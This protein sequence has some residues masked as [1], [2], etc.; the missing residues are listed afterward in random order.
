[1]K[2]TLLLLMTLSLL[3]MPL[4]MANAEERKDVVDTAVAAGQFSILVKA[5]EQAGLVE[6]LKGS[7]PFTV[8]APTD[9]AFAALLKQLDI[10]AEEL[11]ARKDLKD[12]LLYH[13]VPGKVLSTDLKDGM[14]VKTL[15]GSDVTISTNPVKVNDAN[16]VK[17]DIL[18]SNGVIHVIDQVLLPQP[19]HK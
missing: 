19:K 10:T 5:L 4:G 17:P 8:F 16:V 13:V 9:E 12:I 15:Q 11:L 2:K 18:A 7:G 6:T 1:M 3:M 14:K